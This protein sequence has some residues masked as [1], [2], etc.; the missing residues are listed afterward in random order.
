MDPVK[1]LIGCS[2]LIT[3]EE[4][5]NPSFEE[6]LTA[7]GARVHGVSLT[8]TAPPSD[9]AP[10]QA[11]AADLAR[12]DWIVLTSGRAVK[13]LAHELRDL[14]IDPFDAARPLSP[15]WGCVGPGT[16][17]ALRAE[18]GRDPDLVPTAFD[19]ATLARE[20]LTHDPRSSL[21]VLFPAARNA[22][23]ALPAL[24]RDAGHQVDQV[25]AYE[26]EADPPDVSVLLPPEG[27]SWDVVVFT[28]GLAV[29]ILL[30]T[31]AKE[32]GEEGARAWLGAS[33]T[34]VLGLSAAEALREAGIEPSIQAA[35]PTMEDLAAAIHDRLSA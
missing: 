12:Y 18:L 5:S 35:R 20:L 26:I 29:Q 6:R 17:S 7:A 27:T 24:L 21:R 28:S 14:G 33:N 9:P 3:R 34:A 1:P 13:S 2:I 11:A 32:L 15:R 25:V 23:A 19:A 16:A 31:M 22:R 8:R 4:R 10:L 30:Q